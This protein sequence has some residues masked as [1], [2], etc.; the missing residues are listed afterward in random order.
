MNPSL[1]IAPQVII[2]RLNK[3]RWHLWDYHDLE[4]GGEWTYCGQSLRSPK[5]SKAYNAAQVTCTDCVVVAIGRKISERG[6]N[7]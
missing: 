6:A 2:R 5:R 4:D 3:K 1:A 7:Q